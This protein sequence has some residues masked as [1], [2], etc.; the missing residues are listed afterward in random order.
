MLSVAGMSGTRLLAQGGAL[1]AAVSDL[2]LAWQ[3]WSVAALALTAGLAFAAGMWYA[4]SAPRRA[5]RRAEHRLDE[6]VRIVHSSLDSAQRTCELLG[7]FPNLLLTLEQLER[8]DQRQAQLLTTIN[9]IVARQ[10]ER[11]SPQ[12]PAIAAEAP[13]APRV[14]FTITWIRT[15]QDP[16]TELPDQSACQT[17]VAAMLEASQNSAAPCGLLLVKIDRLEHLRNRFGRAAARQF[18]RRMA[19]LCIQ[20]SRDADL[21]CRHSDDTLA[22]L[23]PDIDPQMGCQLADRIRAAIRGHRF[24]LDDETGPEVLVTASFGFTPCDGSDDPQLVLSR[25]GDALDR[26]QRRGRNQ[27]HIH[28]GTAS[29]L[30]AVGVEMPV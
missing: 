6:L 19:R 15:P 28:D 5:L 12:S 25:A 27:L 11:L 29:R 16:E 13:A 26:S 17:N 3:A 14:K 30:C 8:L 7:A 1:E 24:R 20:S 10:R 4:R 2:P 9:G 23:L 18:L 21:V 22:V